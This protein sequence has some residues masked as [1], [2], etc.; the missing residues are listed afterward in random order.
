MMAP[1]RC[2]ACHNAQLAPALGCIARA[3]QEKGGTLA[4]E[5]SVEKV[6]RGLLTRL[7]R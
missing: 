4:A 5:K 2:V 7:L 1:L 6:L 3:L